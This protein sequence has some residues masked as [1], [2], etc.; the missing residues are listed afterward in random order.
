MLEI[1]LARP[2][3]RA[4]FAAGSGL[5]FTGLVA[6]LGF[7]PTPARSALEVVANIPGVYPLDLYD[8]SILSA[9][10][11]RTVTVP[12]RVTVASLTDDFQ[13]RGYST[14]R[15][16]ATENSVPRIILAQLPQ[17]IHTID[18]IDRRKEI[19]IATLLPILLAESERIARLRVRLEDVVRL[20][21]SGTALSED[22][23]AWL[24][25]LAQQFKVEPGDFD[26]LLLRVDSVPASLAIAQAALESGWGTS[27]VAR[28]SQALFGH[29]TGVWREGADQPDLRRFATL[30][31]A[32]VAYV[33]NINTNRAYARLRAARAAMRRN[34]GE[35]DAH[36]LANHLLRYSER[37]AD[38]VRD[39]RT[40]IR[41]NDLLAFDSARFL[42]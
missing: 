22:D 15:V 34:G 7:Q 28:V 42:D 37:G 35:I 27:R 19:F 13:A 36:A 38:Y 21:E 31:D 20:A 12:D 41:S 40:L 17:D 32:V 25:Q 1:A 2:R 4:L 6:V 18:S 16:R 24:A 9:S 5:A 33:E 10:P 3:M 30:T 11:D 23:R 26:E 39:V 29:T 8:T 14:M